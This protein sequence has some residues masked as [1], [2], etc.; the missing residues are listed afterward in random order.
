MND[1]TKNLAL[2]KEA[3]EIDHTLRIIIDL[4]PEENEYLQTL[5]SNLLEDIMVIQAKICGAER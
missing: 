2:Y 3:Q 4:F 1:R 5:K